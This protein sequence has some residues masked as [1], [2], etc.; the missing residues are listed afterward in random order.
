MQF[1]GMSSDFRL[2]ECGR[3]T[4]CWPLRAM[5]GHQ[6]NKFKDWELTFWGCSPFKFFLCMQLG[7][8]SESAL[9]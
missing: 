6:W 5:A 9:F 1:P 2:A 4:D 7:P 3:D 8:V